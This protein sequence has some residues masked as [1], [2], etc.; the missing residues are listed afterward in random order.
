MMDFL[1]ENIDRTV[2]IQ[3]DLGEIQQRLRDLR[4]RVDDE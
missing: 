4:S 1:N 3:E 2:E